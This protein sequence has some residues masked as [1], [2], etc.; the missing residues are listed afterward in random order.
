MVLETVLPLA[1]QEQGFLRSRLEGAPMGF[2]S[3]A[4]RLQ[5][6]SDMTCFSPTVRDARTPIVDFLLHS[7]A[8]RL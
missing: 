4:T 6:Q 2:P 1:A 3:S 7:V 5:Q 8:D